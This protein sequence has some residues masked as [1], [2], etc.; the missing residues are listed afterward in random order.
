[1]KKY[2]VRI[3]K[4]FYAD[5]PSYDD[6]DWNEVNVNIVYDKKTKCAKV[7][8]SGKSLTVGSNENM[9]YM[10]SHNYDIIDG[11]IYIYDASKVLHDLNAFIN[12][13]EAGIIHDERYLDF[14]LNN[15]LLHKEQFEKIITLERDW[16]SKRPCTSYEGI[17]SSFIKKEQ[18][19]INKMEIRP[20]L[21]E[22]F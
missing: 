7:S 8:K 14:C 4:E 19:I 20:Y 17:I 22:Y 2:P 13:V 12:V 16:F 3:S 21:I 15:T 5:L 1:M 11:V 9:I 6:I 18:Y 10:C